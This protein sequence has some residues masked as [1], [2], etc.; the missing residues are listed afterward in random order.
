MH[1]AIDSAVEEQEA[2]LSNLATDII[3]IAY[4]AIL[5]KA[6]CHSEVIAH[7]IRLWHR[8]S[9]RP[10]SPNTVDSSS[11]RVNCGLLGECD[12]ED[13]TPMPNRILQ[14]KQ[15]EAHWQSSPKS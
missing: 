3:R 9:S 11:Q 6:A 7:D 4:V 14:L 2:T 10:P 8:Y 5:V 13:G 12:S 1:S 15:Q